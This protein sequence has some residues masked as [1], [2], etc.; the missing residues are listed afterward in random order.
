[1]TITISDEQKAWFATDGNPCPDGKVFLEKILERMREKCSG[2][3]IDIDSDKP[4]TYDPRF[5]PQTMQESIER[6]QKDGEA[7]VDSMFRGCFEMCSSPKR[8]WEGYFSQ[9]KIPVTDFVNAL[10]LTEK[11]IK[12]NGVFIV[13]D[14]TIPLPEIFQNLLIQL[15]KHRPEKL[16]IFDV[17][18]PID[19]LSKLSI[20]I[21]NLRR[22]NISFKNPNISRFGV[23]S[24]SI[25]LEFKPTGEKL[26]M[27]IE[28]KV[29]G[30]LTM[31]EITG[32]EYD[33]NQRLFERLQHR[34]PVEDPIKQMKKGPYIDPV[35]HLVRY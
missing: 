3:A 22:M 17:D 12:G 23:Y 16:G 26:L 9:M 18:S 33:N 31:G 28:N 19:S 34:P 2:D 15:Y 11:A 20:Y 6:Y 14:K 25:S 10:Y 1:M 35:T 24:P 27:G 30:V 13:S 4:S 21:P 7:C 29:E 8:P 5:K 32:W